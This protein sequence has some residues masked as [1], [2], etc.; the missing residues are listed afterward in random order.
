MQPV[1]PWNYED[2]LDRVKTY[3]PTMWF[4]KPHN[5]SPLQCARWGWFNSGIDELKCNKYA[6]EVGFH[7]DHPYSVVCVVACR[8]RAHSCNATIR[9][10]ISSDHDGQALAGQLSAGHTNI[11]PWH[12]NPCPETFTQ[13][14]A[15]SA[16]QIKDE[17]NAHVKNIL[18]LIMEHPG[19][20]C[21]CPDGFTEAAGGADLG[22]LVKRLTSAGALTVQPSQ[23]EQAAADHATSSLA[24]AMLVSI[25][26]WD[27]HDHDEGARLGCKLCGRRLQLEYFD[28][29]AENGSS[30]SNGEM[31]HK[32]AKTA[33]HALNPATEHRSYCPWV[34]SSETP[35]AA[36]GG[37]GSAVVDPTA[38]PIAEAWSIAGWRVVLQLLLAEVPSYETSTQAPPTTP[39]AR[40]SDQS[41]ES[42][43]VRLWLP[44]AVV[45]H[46]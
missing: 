41:R 9:H 32:R 28:A 13:F 23:S 31:K 15:R 37:S 4:A 27:R 12:D 46:Q 19:C 40:G 29:A 24:K 21:V 11:C 42:V 17:F 2:F 25:F 35:A 5:I 18:P 30:T 8:F 33:K 3:Q 36:T 20:E 44:A 10:D 6:P 34:L 39:D 16:Q 14:P 1:R 26:G 45:V 22:T 38:S 43:T 7:H